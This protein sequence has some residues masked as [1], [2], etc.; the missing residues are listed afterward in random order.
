MIVLSHDTFEVAVSPQIGGAVTRFTAGG[1]DI[2]RPA[3]GG[4][5]GVGDTGCFALV[6]YANRIENGV[7]QAGGREIRL[8]RNMGD[9]PHPLH[10]HGWQTPWRV[11]AVSRAAVTLAFDH[12]GDDWPWAYSAQQSFEIDKDGLRIQ[13]AV[14]NRDAR[15]MPVSLGFHPFFPRLPRTRLSALVKGMWQCN[16][17]ILPT[18]HVAGSPLLDLPHGAALDKAPFVDNCYTDWHGPAHIAQPDDGIDVTLN[19]SPQCRFLHVYTPLGADFFAA[20]P[21]SAMPNAVNRREPAEQTGARTI[22]AGES[23][24]IEM[25]IAVGRP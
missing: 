17:T 19:A 9:H 2:L 8:H 11:E 21:V 6:P 24:G 14:R 10:G 23:F 3:P 18:V 25:H 5:F 1:I 13:L 12:A 22:E 16:E 4:A 15:A 20:E 7:L